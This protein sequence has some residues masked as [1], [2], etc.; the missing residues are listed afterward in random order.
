MATSVALLVPLFEC[1]A[2]HRAS[3]KVILGSLWSD[4]CAFLACT[5]WTTILVDDVCLRDC[6]CCLCIFTGILVSH[7]VFKWN[8]KSIVV[9]YAFRL[10]KCSI[11]HCWKVSNGFF[12]YKHKY[13]FLH[14]RKY[15][16]SK[17]WIK[18]MILFWKSFPCAGMVL[19]DSFIFKVSSQAKGPVFTTHDIHTWQISLISPL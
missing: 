8:C 16:S 9:F 4:L 5:I 18:V 12:N 10:V 7:W 1:A 3:T 15:V 11:I 2:G 19:A 17:Q 14:L 6:T 13:L